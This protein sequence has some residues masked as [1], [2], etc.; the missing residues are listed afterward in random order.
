[1]CPECVPPPLLSCGRSPPR[2]A[3]RPP[4]SEW[5]DMP[6]T[7]TGERPEMPAPPL[8]AGM[9]AWPSPPRFPSKDPSPRTPLRA[10]MCASS[11]SIAFCALHHLLACIA[12]P[13]SLNGPAP[14]AVHTYVLGAALVGSPPPPAPPA[15]SLGAGTCP[16]I[17]ACMSRVDRSGSAMGVGTMFGSAVGLP[18]AKVHHRL[19]CM[20]MPLVLKG[21]LSHAEQY[22][23][24][25]PAAFSSSSAIS[26]DSYAPRHARPTRAG[27]TLTNAGSPEQHAFT[28][29]LG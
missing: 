23:I 28:V 21:P 29:L 22:K 27:A 6:G 5:M 13:F 18:A 10:A 24:F 26:L 17:L 19:M 12:M 8:I 3:G 11:S 7:T 15:P 25:S 16:V 20:R 4:E 14:H 1:M 9:T 2:S